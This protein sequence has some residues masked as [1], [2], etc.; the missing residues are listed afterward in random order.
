[1]NEELT[2]D[3]RAAM[4]SRIVGGA[5]D[6]T[7]VAAVWS[8]AHGMATLVVAGHL[9]PEGMASGIDALL[10]LARSVAAE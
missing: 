3:E 4:R 5:R 9:P 6:I 1:M 8:L 10:S 7:A 2:A